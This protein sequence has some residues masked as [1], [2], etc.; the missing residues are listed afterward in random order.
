MTGEEIRKELFSRQDKDYRDF[1][2]KTLPTVDKESMIGVRTPELRSLAKEW[3][4]RDD[5]E[6]FLREL[7]HR[8]FDENQ[9]HAFVISGMKDFEKCMEETELF[10]PYVDNWA[11]CDQMSPKIFKKHRPELLKHIKKWIKSD[12][13]YTIRFGTGMLMEHFLEEDF[14]IKYPELVSKLRS[15]EYYVNMMTAWYFATA[16]AKQYEAVLPFI[17]NKKL[18]PWTHNK[19]IQKAVESYR[20]TPEQKEHLKSLKVKKGRKGGKK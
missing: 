2:A 18:D 17:E 10:M 20:I 3:G 7:P 15:E 8:Y 5:I 19:A 14:D 13:T 4:K 9:I 6:V 16:L 12:R 1:Q 11:T